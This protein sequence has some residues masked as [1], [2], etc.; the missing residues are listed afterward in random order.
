[1]DKGAIER[2]EHVVSTPFK[3]ISYTEVIALLQQAVADG[4]KFEPENMDIQWGMDLPSEHERCAST[5]ATAL[6]QPQTHYLTP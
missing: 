1:V 3:R 5:A 4:K 6:V 2:L